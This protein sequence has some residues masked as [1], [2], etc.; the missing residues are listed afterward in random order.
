MAPIPDS[1]IVAQH[2]EVLDMWARHGKPT[3]TWGELPWRNIPLE[4]PEG[5]TRN[6]VV[7]EV[8]DRLTA[9]GTVKISADGDTFTYAPAAD[10]VAAVRRAHLEMSSHVTNAMASGV[11][12][13]ALGGITPPMGW[14]ISTLHKLA[15][16]ALVA[17]GTLVIEDGLYRNT[18]AK[19]PVAAPAPKAEPKPV[20][21]PA[22]VAAKVEPKPVQ[23][24]RTTEPAPT[25]PAVPA[26]APVPALEKKVDTLTA[27]VSR[28]ERKLDT[29][30]PPPTAEKLLVADADTDVK[31]LLESV[32]VHLKLNGAM[33]EAAIHRALPGK[34]KPSRSNPDP[35]DRRL[36]LGEALTLGVDA[37]I[38]AHDPLTRT[39]RLVTVTNL[40]PRAE[41][42][43]RVQRVLDLRKSRENAA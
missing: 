37:K 9:K 16:D 26:V 8:F 34:S 30:P 27:A 4:L 23:A 36:R 31:R 35:I 25:K 21:A 29:M 43:R 19:A 2:A 7:Q 5:V 14:D 1:A 24:A 38:L 40:M 32:C 20:A 12:R 18:K 28:V 17:D 42:D 33:R 10:A 15:M 39:Y 6:D 22:P 41:L 3:A 11:F 13:G